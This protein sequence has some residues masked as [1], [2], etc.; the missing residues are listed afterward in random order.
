MTGVV[1]GNPGNLVDLSNYARDFY[2]FCTNL[3]RGKPT[4]KCRFPIPEKALNCCY[5]ENFTSLIQEKKQNLF[6]IL[7]FFKI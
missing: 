1:P 4:A 6:Q 3:E 2:D 7:F 5:D